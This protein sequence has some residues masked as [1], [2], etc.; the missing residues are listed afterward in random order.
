MP[1]QSV[2]G[3]AVVLSALMVLGAVP[4]IVA[5]A[6]AREHPAGSV[7]ALSAVN[8]YDE[9]TR[10][11]S[12]GLDTGAIYFD[13]DDYSGDT[14]GTVTLSD[15]NY[16]R[17]G[18]PNP[19]ATWTIAFADDHN[20]SYGTG[21][22]YEL[23]YALNYS[24]L[25]VL[26]LTAGGSSVQINL[27]VNAYGV[28]LETDQDSYLAGHSGTVYWGLD[29]AANSAPFTDVSSLQIVGLYESAAGSTLALP[30]LT[31]DL[32]VASLGS[33]PFTVPTDAAS[34]SSISFVIWANQS[35]KTPYENWSVQGQVSVG[36]G[37]V[38]GVSLS[39]LN[40][41][42]SCT[43]FP[44]NSPVLV[45]IAV[46]V[47]SDSGDVLESGLVCAIS[48][49][50]GTTME[51]APSGTPTSLTTNS[52]GIASFVFLANSTEF[53]S[54]HA[55]SVQVNVSDPLN[56]AVK[57]G[58]SIRFYVSVAPT[59]ARLQVLLGAGVYYGGDNATGTWS[60]GGSSSSGAPGWSAD[61]WE[62]W[63]EGSGGDTGAP[64]QVF[65][66]GTINTTA[67]TGTFSAALPSDFQG[68][69]WVSV[70]AANA[71][72]TVDEYAEA[73]VLA[74]TL[75]INPSET[76]YQ[77]G[78]TI[79]VTIQ[80]EGQLFNGATFYE[81]A[82][83]DNGNVLSSG[84]V[85]GT[86]FSVKVPTV[87]PPTYIEFHVVA[88]TS[89]GG[90]IATASAESDL[91]TGLSLAAS[92]ST[93]SSYSDG[94]YKPGTSV[95]ISY[96]LTALGT[97][98]L[99]AAVELEILPGAG[100]LG[101]LIGEDIEAP[102]TEIYSSVATTGTVSYTIP[103]GTPNGID[104]L[105]VVA[106]PLNGQC[107]GISDGCLSLTQLSINVNNNP[108]ALGYELGGTGGITLG[109]LLL[110]LVVIVIF[111]LGLLWVRRR[112][113]GGSS[114]GRVEPPKPFTS[115]PPASPPA[116]ATTPPEGGTGSPPDL[117]SGPGGSS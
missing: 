64:Y 28:S 61:Y 14:T 20:D 53:S 47:D 104:S 34:Y 17:D 15:Q 81:E 59:V 68:N 26:N 76:V 89:S 8:G 5:A 108:P 82:Q 46:D 48:F 86:S 73:T 30:G 44:A 69:L 57:L 4:S 71:T 109:W 70:E 13:A 35:S 42:V 33:I 39:F 92:V 40:C 107:T 55:N 99:P 74:P 103:S 117:P 19:A 101:L 96:S 72:D 50:S 113:G 112:T 62:A 105:S 100:L 31:K 65:D 27:T 78:D 16:S 95:T 75:L 3:L 79:T 63:G 38:T 97:S 111:I 52:S 22:F 106:V 10:Y 1:R 41:G 83:D 43:T 80:T 94:S 49:Y 29:R 24:G 84:P 102:G 32:T 2:V 93:A 18:V 98:K 85:S 25:W 54:S 45:Q 114:G 37:A 7:L 21:N 115:T 90:A 60:L 12:P 116:G 9:T 6:G 87:A 58:N 36:V 51:T 67:T 23:P 88:Q 77:P 56:P 66:L 110:F 91:I 11:F